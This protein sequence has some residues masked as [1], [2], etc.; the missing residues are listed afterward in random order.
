VSEATIGESVL[1]VYL[2]IRN[3]MICID[4]LLGGLEHARP[5]RENSAQTF[6]RDMAA[7]DRKDGV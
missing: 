1:P 5:G 2:G 6:E 7:K 4:M 3:E